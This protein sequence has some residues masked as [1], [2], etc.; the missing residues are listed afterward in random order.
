MLKMIQV[1][2]AGQ[3]KPYFMYTMHDFINGDRAMPK[4]DE[5]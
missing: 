1:V 2:L 3:W 4:K 5:K